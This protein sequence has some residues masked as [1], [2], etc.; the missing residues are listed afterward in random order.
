VPRRRTIAADILSSA[1]S[2]A[3]CTPQS[4]LRLSAYPGSRGTGDPA[5]TLM[6]KL[7]QDRS[8]QMKGSQTFTAVGVGL[9]VSILWLL[10]W[11]IAIVRND[12]ARKST[13]EA[14]TIAILTAI[15]EEL[16]AGNYDAAQ[17]KVRLLKGCIQSS[18]ID[19]SITPERE[20]R[21]ILEENP[22][23]TKTDQKRPKRDQKD[24]HNP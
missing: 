13:F 3:D 1:L 14:P 11:R 8:T 20:Y 9:V 10:V 23:R 22:E 18:L 5:P 7:N 16:T 24:R 6:K 19:A 15:E 4:L 2:D 17:R 12:T 21:V